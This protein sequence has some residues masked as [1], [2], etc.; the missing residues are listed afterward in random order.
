MTLPYAI[1]DALDQTATMGLIVLKA[2]ETIELDLRRLLPDPK[3]ALHVSRIESGDE[4]TVD[5][6]AAMKERLTASASLFASTTRFDVVGY[7]CTSATS[8]LGIDTVA[9]LVGEGCT[10]H[11]VTEPVSALLAAC[12]T[13]GV[14]RLGIL[15]PYVE[16]VG[17]ALAATLRTH[18]LDIV[19]MGSFGEAREANVARVTGQSI[20]DGAVAVAAT[21]APEALFLSCTNLRTL[22][23][24][25]AIE[26]R[27]GLPVLTSNTVLAWHM[28]QLAG[29]PAGHAGF[30]RLFTPQM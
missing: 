21:G 3:L 27:T 7:A 14:S 4:L 28:A 11:H 15:S 12:K 1:D 26:A 13:L 9:Q 17:E 19:S 16:S 25:A 2:D 10:T 20:I 22:D 8:V 23:V 18:G 30:G 5:T 24:I 29:V 6:I